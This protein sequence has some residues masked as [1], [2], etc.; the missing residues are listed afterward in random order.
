MSQSK[1][2]YGADS[3]GSNRVEIDIDSLP[4][5]Y[6]YSAGLIATDTVTLTDGTQYRKTY[7]WSNGTLTSETGWV[8]V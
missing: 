5:A 6:T 7:T 4:H 8:K 3:S 1:I 2:V